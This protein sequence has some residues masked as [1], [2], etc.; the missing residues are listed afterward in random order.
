MDAKSYLIISEDSLAF[1]KAFPDETIRV[2]GNFDFGIKKKKEQL[3]LYTSEGASVD[4]TGYHIVPLDSTF[5]MSLLLPHLDN[6]DME[7]WEVIR[8]Y[9][10][11]N[12]EN[13]F[14]KQSIIKATQDLY[15]RI[16]IA[17]GILLSCFLVLNI[18]SQRRKRMKGA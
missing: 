5:T 16:G 11:P 2:V 12:T 1:R 14:Y 13:P 7:N 3:G 15:L 17:L 8:G 6:S 18:R 9:G 10:T 4:S